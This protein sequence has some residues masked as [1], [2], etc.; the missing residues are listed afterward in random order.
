MHH[1]ADLHL[2]IVALQECQH[3]NEVE[4]EDAGWDSRFSVCR[5]AAILYRVT[6]KHLILDSF[7]GDRWVAIVF[8]HFVLTQA[9]P[10][11]GS[12]AMARLPG[13]DWIF[14]MFYVIIICRNILAIYSS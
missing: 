13:T 9:R 8:R 4:V 10:D 3:L 12:F 14:M 6:W 7:S 2:S 11:R 1:L 5:R